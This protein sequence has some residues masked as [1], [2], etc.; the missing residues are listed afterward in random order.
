MG[1]LKKLSWYGPAVLL[2]VKESAGKGLGMIG[3][4]T[5]GEAK[6]ELR[7]GHGKV[8]GTLQR[9][10]HSANPTYGF[11]GDNVKPSAKTP[12]RGGRV[13]EPGMVGN[14]IT[15]LVGSGMRYALKI[16]NLYRYLVIGLDRVRPRFEEIMKRYGS[17]R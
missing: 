6:K 7:A 10:I 3:L 11:S 5:E 12:E 1:G 13:A 2:Q 17:W 15:I 14:R 8:T 9:S 4:A 16:H